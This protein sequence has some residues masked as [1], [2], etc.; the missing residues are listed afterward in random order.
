MFTID[1]SKPVLVTG[2]G[3]YVASWI[4]KQLLDQGYTV[5]GTVRSLDAQDRYRHLERMAA[6][7]AFQPVAADLLVKGSFDAAVQGCEVV[8]HTASPFLG[9]GV[10]DPQRQLIEPAL[11]GTLN[12]LDAVQKSGSVKK[13]VL[14]SSVAAIAGDNADLQRTPQGLFT[15]ADWNT[16][17]SAHYQPYP[18]SKTVAERAAWTVAHSQ[19]RWRLVTINPGF[20]MGPS[21][22]ARVD[23]TSIVTL[24]DFLSGRFAL[25]VPEFAFG[26]VDVRDVAAAHL[27]A[28]FRPDAEGRHIVVSETGSLFG[29]AQAIEQ[30]FPGRYRV[31]KWTLPKA[32]AYVAGPGFGLNWRFITRNIGLP[33]AFDTTKSQTRLGLRYI[34]FSQT[35]QDHVEQ[36]L[37]DGLI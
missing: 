20:V 27:A 34:P 35:I 3:G 12:V 26:V 2:A 15:E 16:S 13:V 23:S 11:E 28:A 7:G 31:P 6:P 22:T 17:S 25:G 24:R 30:H 1:H 8:I 37:A 32:L 4:V 14:T 21:L 29:I 9:V 5:R 18:Y 33:V 10:Q 19:D 36:L